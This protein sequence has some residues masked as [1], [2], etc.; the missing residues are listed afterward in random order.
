[1]KKSMF[2]YKPIFITLV[3]LGL[4]TSCITSRKTNYLQNPSYKIPAY[5]D[6]V[7]YQE[8]KIA[9]GDRLYIRL[10]SKDKN[11]N[12]RVNGSSQGFSLTSSGGEGADLYAYLVEEN[13]MIK[14]PSVGDIYLLGK[15]L[16]EVKKEIENSL[17]PLFKDRFAVNVNLV[18]RYF[19]IIG[20]QANNKYP[21]IKEKMNIFQA[22]AMAGDI[23]TYGDRSK[24]RIIRESNGSTQ[25]KTFDIRSKDIIDSEF[26]YIQPNDV[27]YIQDVKESFF[28]V[29]SL[30]S[31]L[32]VIFSTISFGLFIYNLGKL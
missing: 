16:R 15:S 26:Y 1:M 32:S 21:I 25:I 22:L 29:S 20:S 19:S 8:Y 14:L 18:E 13:G 11:L 30:G 5:N 10:L 12:A 6:S 27:I 17:S 4:L 2:R 23:N 9:K 31:A 7:K 24:I 28:S 3:F